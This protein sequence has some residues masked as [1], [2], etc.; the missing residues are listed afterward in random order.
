MFCYTISLKA[1]REKFKEIC[2][3]IEVYF[4]DCSLEK[5]QLLSDLLLAVDY[6][7]K[8]R[9]KVEDKE[10]KVVCENYEVDAVY[11]DS[12]IDLKAVLKENIIV[13]YER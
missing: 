4:H 13:E 7:L 5:E 1:D 3:L 9:Y 10:I 11:I 12:E 2:H 8:Q 6:Y